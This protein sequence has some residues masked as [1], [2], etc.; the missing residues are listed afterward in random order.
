M[1]DVGVWVVVVLIVRGIIHR[2]VVGLAVV[3]G[4]TAA[5]GGIV[6]IAVVGITFCV[7]PREQ[8]LT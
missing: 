1:D 8:R 6:I 3:A 7:R 2:E 5:E 4:V